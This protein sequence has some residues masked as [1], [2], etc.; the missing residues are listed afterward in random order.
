MN[1]SIFGTPF[2]MPFGGMNTCFG[3]PFY[4]ATN[5]W[6]MISG[7][8]GFPVPFNYGGNTPMGYG[9][10]TPFN[11]GMPFATPYAG[12]FG[13]PFNY[14]PINYGFNTPFFMNAM[15]NM[16]GMPMGFGGTPFMSM[17]FFG[18]PMF[19]PG[20]AGVNTNGSEQNAKTAA[21]PFGYAPIFPYGL[22]PFVAATNCAGASKAA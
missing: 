21:M 1:T 10:N 13:N 16:G 17:P 7:A 9:V 20:F 5:P 2:T 18:A 4:G 19:M 6:S 14:S 3:G 15:W 22:N 11:S 8:P 12:G